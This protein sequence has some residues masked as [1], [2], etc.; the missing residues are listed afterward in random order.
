MTKMTAIAT[1]D[2]VQKGSIGVIFEVEFVDED[3]A[4][5]DI[6][7]ATT[8][9]ILAQFSDGTTTAFTAA[10]SNTGTDGKIRYV[11]ESADDIS[12]VGT[13]I[14]QGHVVSTDYDYYGLPSTLLVNKNI[15]IE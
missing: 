10:F 11:T 4:V 7:T 13:L 2:I 6:S 8:K 14:I 15:I 9:E 5:I 3:G 1:Q 12:I